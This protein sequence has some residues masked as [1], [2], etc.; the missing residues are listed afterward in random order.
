M[1][2]CKEEDLMENCV[3]G[4]GR[5]RGNTSGTVVTPP[6]APTVTGGWITATA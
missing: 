6:S 4:R 1:S 5:P 2:T 3:W